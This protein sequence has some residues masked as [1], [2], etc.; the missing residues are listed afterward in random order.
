MK[1]LTPFVP[2]PLARLL[3]NRLRLSALG[4]GI[5]AFF[6]SAAYIFGLT[7]VFGLLATES[8]LRAMLADF[9]DVGILLAICPAIW[10]YYLWQVKSIP[11]ELSGLE[12]SAQ[13]PKKMAEEVERQKQKVAKSVLPMLL[14][15]AVALLLSA[16]N[17][18]LT[19][20]RLGETWL[21][22]NWQMI[23]AMQ[24]IRLPAFYMVSMV[25][26][27]LTLSSI[28]LNRIVSRQSLKIILLHPDGRGGLSSLGKYAIT[29]ASAVPIAGLYLGL[30]WAREGITA[31][32]PGGLYFPAFLIYVLVSPF[33]L[34]LPI[35]NAH[36]QMKTAKSRLL[37]EIAELF[38]Q[39]Y[40]GLTRQLHQ[41]VLAPDVAIRLRAFK[42]MYH[43]AENAP[44]W[45]IDLTLLSQFIIAIIIPLII[46]IVLRILTDLLP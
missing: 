12:Q 31:L 2:D 13:D 4:G 36:E 1:Y 32:A 33:L 15:T 26:I 19:L 29:S 22:H 34:A 20:P 3:V 11:E 39:E 23:A 9:S 14:S 18:K 41:N 42:K 30:V 37:G 44:V 27:K 24:I 40:A 10:V 17:L 25:A 6:L 38:E 46:P 8:N 45:P 35:L 7:A 28:M 16:L 21:A 5:V 43:T